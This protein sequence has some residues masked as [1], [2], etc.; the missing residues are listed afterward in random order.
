MQLRLLDVKLCVGEQVI[1]ACVIPVQM[2][3]NHMLNICGVNA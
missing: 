2:G 3:Q 1:V